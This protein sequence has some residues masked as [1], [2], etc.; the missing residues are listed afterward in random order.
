V[1]S[2]YEYATLI[3]LFGP[4]VVEIDSHGD[5]CLKRVEGTCIFQ[6][7]EGLCELQPLGLKP[8][9]CKVWP[10]KV[11]KVEDPGYA[12]LDELF[13]Y[14]GEAYK[15]YV[16][17]SCLGIGHGTREN[18]VEAIKEVIEVKKDP[19]RPQC[20]TTAQLKPLQLARLSTIM[21]LSRIL[22]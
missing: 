9:A 1:L 21:P 12:S 15:A 7:P 14:R 5:P 16:H 17:S 2:A 20:Y 19:R 10:F 4:G 13:V 3:K 22:A 6:S 11:V 18:L 8:L